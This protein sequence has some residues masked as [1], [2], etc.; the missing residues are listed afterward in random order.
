MAY[1]E[2]IKR[3][4][5]G[6]IYK[7]K[8]WENHPPRSNPGPAPDI[9]PAH[10]PGGLLSCELQPRPRPLRLPRLRSLRPRSFALPRPVLLRFRRLL[11]PHPTIPACPRTGPLNRDR[12]PS[13]WSPRYCTFACFHR[14]RS[15]CCF[16][17]TSPAN[18][19]TCRKTCLYVQRPLACTCQRTTMKQ[20]LSSKKSP[21]TGQETEIQKYGTVANR[22]LSLDHK[23][24]LASA[25]NLNRI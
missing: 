23:A 5:I 2:H 24:R 18:A 19:A 1:T 15:S 9:R 3:I 7:R 14:L 21:L 17:S 11:P 22:P 12:A 25:G 16:G 4:Y 20:N 10:R 8:T 13:L 6:S